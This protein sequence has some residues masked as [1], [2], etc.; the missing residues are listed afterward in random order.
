MATFI[1]HH[2]AETEAFAARVA[3]TLPPGTVIGLQGDLGAGKTVFVK[4][5]ARG[6]E[7]EE[8]VHSPT[9][10]LV[11]LYASGRLPLAHLDLYRLENDEAIIRSG[12][13]EY[14]RPEGIAV[15]EWIDR[16]QGPLPGQ[17]YR[18]ELRVMNE[19]EREIIH[20]TDLGA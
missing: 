8:R 12:L 2:P 11:N 10:T 13:E 3:R 9:F 7:I 19:S 5:L 18:I 6:L 15:I 17:F 14:F 1:S 20:D 4:G 16:W